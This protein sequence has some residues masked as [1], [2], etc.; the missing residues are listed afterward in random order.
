MLRNGRVFHG[1]AELPVGVRTSSSP[2][3]IS[4][5]CVGKERERKKSY[6]FHIFTLK[7]RARWPPPLC[8]TRSNKSG[9][10]T[11]FFAFK[12]KLSSRFVK[13]L[14]VCHVFFLSLSLFGP[15]RHHRLLPTQHEERWWRCLYIYTTRQG[16]FFLLRLRLVLSKANINLNKPTTFMEDFLY[17]FVFSLSFYS[18]DHLQRC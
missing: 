8:H 12:K 11:F 6:S 4:F 15:A 1:K 14:V 3:S 9:R 13:L 2:L 16:S 7:L 10:I 18:V 17:I 5:L